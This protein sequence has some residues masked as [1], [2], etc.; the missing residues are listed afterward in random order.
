MNYN[1]TNSSHNYQYIMSPSGRADFFSTMLFIFFLVIFG[2]LALQFLCFVS[3]YFLALVF[4][5]LLLVFLLV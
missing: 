3:P 1:S 4:M 5:Q 2:V